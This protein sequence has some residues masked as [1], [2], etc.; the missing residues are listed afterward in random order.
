MAAMSTNRAGKTAVH[1]AIELRHLVEKQHAV[2]REGDLS[3]PWNRAAADERNVRDGVV[4]CAKGA[5]RQEAACGRQRAG[6]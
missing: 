1:A 3:R 4:R 2:V 5:R 6:D